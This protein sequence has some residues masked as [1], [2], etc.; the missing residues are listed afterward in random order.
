MHVHK[1]IKKFG[2]SW[3]A[4]DHL[5]HSSSYLHS[6]ARI[7]KL[8][9]QVRLV[10]ILRVVLAFPLVA[11]LSI[12]LQEPLYTAQSS[13]TTTYSTQFA[14]AKLLSARFN[15]SQGTEMAF[16]NFVLS[17][18]NQSEGPLLTTFQ[19]G[20]ETS[21]PL[22]VDSAKFTFTSDAVSWPDIGVRVPTNGFTPTQISRVDNQQTV[23]LS[24]QSMGFYGRGTELFEIR[25]GINILTGASNTKH[26]V[27]MT[28]DLT[29]HNPHALL[30]G[31]SYTAEATFQILAHPNG[32]LTASP[33]N[34][35]PQ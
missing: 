7:L 26:S 33:G 20:P 14:N 34:L 25:F 30:I 19:F 21:Q 27:L 17:S 9:N 28:V 6:Y 22:Y 8:K 13:V 1:C 4:G 3:I 11:G 29:G 5:L 24:Y 31:Q 35:L 2:C 12:A 10:V 15:D 18:K 16:F 23:I 32:L